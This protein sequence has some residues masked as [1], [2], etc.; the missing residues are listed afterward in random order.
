MRRAVCRRLGEELLMEFHTGDF[1]G[2][3]F[4]IERNGSFRLSPL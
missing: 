4:R 1:G 3:N 2:L